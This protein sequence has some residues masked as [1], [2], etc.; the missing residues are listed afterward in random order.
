MR[1]TM[2]LF[3][4]LIFILSSCTT[5]EM[6]IITF[7]TNGGTVINQTEFELNQTQMVLPTPEKQDNQFDGWYLDVAL[8]TPFTY[9]TV[10]DLSSITL[11]AKWVYSID[12]ISFNSNGGSIIAPIQVN[13]GTSIVEPIP[14]FPNHI[15]QGWYID[16]TL[17]QKYNF[18]NMP[19]ENILLFAKWLSIDDIDTYIQQVLTSENFSLTYSMYRSLD[20]IDSSTQIYSDSDYYIEVDT[21]YTIMSY[22]VFDESFEAYIVKEDQDYMS[23]TRDCSDDEVNCWSRYV[24]SDEEYQETISTLQFNSMIDL[25]LADG[26]NMSWFNQDLLT[27]T[28]DEDYYQDM[29]DL[30]FDEDTQVIDLYEIALTDQGF[31]LSFFVENPELYWGI[32]ITV[33]DIM[34]THIQVPSFDVCEEDLF[35]YS[36]DEDG[37]IITGYYGDPI[38]LMIPN[39]V[40]HT[41]VIG[42]DSNAFEGLTT[43]ERVELPNTIEVIGDSAFANC[44]SLD[45]VYINATSV[46]TLGVDVFSN[47]SLTLKIYV[48]FESLSLY[49]NAPNWS[50]YA[51][52][53]LA[54]TY[55]T[56]TFDG[57]GGTLVSG[58]EIQQISSGGSAVAPV[59]ENGSLYLYWNVSFVNISQDLLVTAQWSTT[60][61]TSQ[62][63]TFTL[64]DDSTYEVTSY[65][66]SET[67]VYIQD[68]YLGM[69]VTSIGRYA[70]E[71]NST[72]SH[73]VMPDSITRIENGAFYNC[74]FLET[75][76][77]SNHLTYIGPRTFS[78]CENLRD[79]SFPASLEIIDDGAFA[80][81]SHITSL[82]L[83]EGLIEIGDAAFSGLW[84]LNSVTIPASVEHLG[85]MAFYRCGY[86]KNI[87]VSPDNLYYQSFDGVLYNK[88]GTKLIFYP[89][90]KGNDVIF[91]DQLVTI[92]TYA[93]YDCTFLTSIMLP[94]Q[95]TE[96]EDRAF[97]GCDRLEEIY[98][99]SSVSIIGE[100]AFLGSYENLVIYTGASAEK[101]QWDLTWNNNNFSVIWNTSTYIVTFDGNGATLISGIEKQIVIANRDAVAPIYDNEGINFNGWNISFTNVI[102]N[103]TVIAQWDPDTSTD[104]IVFTL[105]DDNTY[106]V[107][108]YTGSSS[109]IRIN[110]LY[111]DKPVTSIGRQAFSGSVSLTKVYLPDSLIKIDQY[112]F[113]D[114]A[115]L[116]SINLPDSLETIE[117]Y[118]FYGCSSLTEIYIPSG[119]S[120]IGSTVF[121][122]TYSLTSINVSP[123]N[124]NFKS[125][126]GMLLN[127]SGEILFSVP[128]GLTGLVSIPDGVTHILTGAINGGNQITEIV[129]P[130]SLLYISSWNFYKC[131]VL[132]NITL[133]SII[134]PEL[135]SSVFIDCSSNLKICVRGDIIDDYKTA[136]NWSDFADRLF[137][138][139]P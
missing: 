30:L 120:Y 88:L 49:Q 106:E 47:T 85:D 64:K 58:Q 97:Q 8:T 33:T 95:I 118:A 42:I 69:P 52:N 3:I 76:V 74:I 136:A 2:F 99:P 24:I 104:G 113:V 40:S 130:E 60:P 25:L 124:P 79:V 14:T 83:P 18:V 61:I 16:S 15:F 78:E 92:G 129:M 131:T 51:N 72:L 114:F 87:F 94:Q 27:F 32:T 75:V 90:N 71:S 7:E 93:F 23:F 56:I 44:T 135:D 11:Y 48:P 28:L 59:Y 102:S 53:I 133:F 17:I 128:S 111:L 138:I 10:V 50:M 46:P 110:N 38:D 101:A 29:S 109:I 6:I 112:A 21:I 62:G 63:L 22:P 122:N 5:N 121:A 54:A 100:Y 4:F 89:S 81:C 19:N 9:D 36:Y 132:E 13:P 108:G 20:P 103:L 77:F 68:T 1:K 84:N 107:T 125:V 35:N 26:L 119:V 126:N 123:D 86:L 37:A 134:L 39:Q 96:I 43:L 66:G 116:I 31:A 70:F 115:D 91:P 137:S 45:V 12:G 117:N 67:N 127:K 98:I 41:D 34:Q 82:E 139:L 55:Y 57:N 105:K 80:G 65:T 73:L